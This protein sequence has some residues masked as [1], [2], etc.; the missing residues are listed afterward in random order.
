MTCAHCEL[1]WDLDFEPSENQWR[2]A[3]GIWGVRYLAWRL[4][5]VLDFDNW[6]IGAKP[7]NA[8]GG[9]PVV[10]GLSG[11]PA[12]PKVIN[13]RSSSKL[14]SVPWSTRWVMY[15]GFAAELH[16]SVLFLVN[17]APLGCTSNSQVSPKASWRA[18]LNERTWWNNWTYCSNE[19]WMKDGE[20]WV[21][22]VQ[23]TNVWQHCSLTA[24]QRKI[25][26]VDI[27]CLDQCHGVCVHGTSN[28]QGWRKRFM[29]LHLHPCFRQRW[30]M[31]VCLG[32]P[33]H[34]NKGLCPLKK[35]TVLFDDGQKNKVLDQVKEKIVEQLE[36]WSMNERWRRLNANTRQYVP[37]RAS[38]GQHCSL[39]A[40]RRQTAY[41]EQSWWRE[42]DMF[43]AMPWC[44][45][46]WHKLLPRLTQNTCCTVYRFTV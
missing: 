45:F 14:A 18:I 40:V 21:C 31:Q 2:A 1:Y 29:D 32:K 8:S 17:L 20:G 7:W 36:L 46:P 37:L 3:N 41:V 6:S 35:P 16:W 13:L 4:F 25:G 24:V 9:Q 43:G 19:C 30:F 44:S 10:F 15:Q 34:E 33:S 39:S 38:M 28:S 27:T 26:C 12:P 42:F 23:W 11:N 22:W 5:W